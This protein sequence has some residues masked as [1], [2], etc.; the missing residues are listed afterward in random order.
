MVDQVSESED[1]R[2]K[3]FQFI[4]GKLCLDYCNTVGGKRGAIPRE[5]LN[6]YDDLLSWSEEAGLTSTSESSALRTKAE[7]DPAEA[8]SVLSRAINL[9]EGIYRIL[10]A[11]LEGAAPSGN[12]LALL[13]S[14]LARLMGRMRISPDATGRAFSWQWA[15]GEA[16]M[17]Q[18][19]GPLAHS[20]A[21]LLAS[22]QDLAHVHQCR[23]DNCGWLFIDSSRNHSRC[24]CDMRDCGNRAKVRRHRQKH[25]I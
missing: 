20:A 9:R 16:E 5:K 4:A 8:A 25:R 2:N 21:S 11:T 7:T 24:W 1:L 15:G 14:E 3:R 23:G 12:D 22:P 6:S 10:L 13:N 18:P 19:L 17:D